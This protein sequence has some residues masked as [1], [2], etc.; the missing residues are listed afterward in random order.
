MSGRS[1]SRRNSYGGSS[2][3]SRESSPSRS[4]LF[5]R[6]GNFGVYGQENYY[7][8]WKGDSHWSKRSRD[9]PPSARSYLQGSEDFA[10]GGW[11]KSQSV[12]FGC[13]SCNNS[14]SY[15]TNSPRYRSGSPRT[16]GYY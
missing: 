12:G 4:D 1:L 8:G 10:S 13:R 3:W 11:R 9:L 14:G 5:H 16:R 7:S 6:R 15:R 2:K